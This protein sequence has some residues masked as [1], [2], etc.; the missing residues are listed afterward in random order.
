MKSF[1]LFHAVA[2]ELLI[3]SWATP[4]PRPFKWTSTTAQKNFK[5]LFTTFVWKLKLF[6]LSATRLSRI[7]IISLSNDKNWRGKD[8]KKRN[9]FSLLSC[10]FFRDH[11]QAQRCS[12]SFAPEKKKRKKIII[13]S[14]RVREREWIFFVFRFI[15]ARE[16]TQSLEEKSQHRKRKK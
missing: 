10:A 14:S 16:T 9:Y 11:I 6:Q 15:L 8:E 5:K 7:S 12:S 2:V 13:E 1:R 3:R 4:A